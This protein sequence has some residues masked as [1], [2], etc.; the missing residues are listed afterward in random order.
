MHAAVL[1]CI[2]HPYLL[3]LSRQLSAIISMQLRAF[4]G[5]GEP[6]AGQFEAAAVSIIEALLAAGFRPCT[7]H[8]TAMPAFLR[9]SQVGQMLAVLD[10]F[11]LYDR[12]RSDALGLPRAKCYSRG[13]KPNDR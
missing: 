13:L 10:P 9:P 12:Q 11:D 3:P 5:R 7:W 6:F 8:N 1:V 2:C 4:W